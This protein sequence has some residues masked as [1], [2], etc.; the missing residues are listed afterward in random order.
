MKKPALITIGRAEK[1]NFPELNLSGVPAR[2]DTGAKTSAVWA[3]KVKE[4]EGTLSFRLFGPSSELYKPKSIKTRQ[5]SRRIIASSIG[6]SQ[7]RYVVKLLI[8]VGDKNIRA[9]FTLA[10]RSAQVYP[11]LLGRNVLRG[12]FIVDVRRGKPLV[13]REQAR[14]KA[15]QARKAKV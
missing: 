13:T 11:I 8:S 6:A 9:S 10:N 3:T 4:E 15:L 12:K 14:S 2:V 1:I 5:F 7:E